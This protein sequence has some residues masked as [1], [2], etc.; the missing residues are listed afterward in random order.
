[1]LSYTSFNKKYEL[2]ILAMRNSELKKLTKFFKITEKT[3]WSLQ[4]NKVL[5]KVCA[6][7]S[8]V[9]II[10]GTPCLLLLNVK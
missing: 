1:M 3:F 2:V 6:L 9:L 5:S 8:D 4:S 7:S 10:S